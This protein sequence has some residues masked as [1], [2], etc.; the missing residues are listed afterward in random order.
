MF[1][2]LLENSGLKR[3]ASWASLVTQCL[4]LSFI[5]HIIAAVRS[6]GFY[7]AD[8]HFQIIE[9]M[10]YKLGRSP[11]LDL[12]LEYGQL[13][14]PW[15]MSAIFGVLTTLWKALKITSPFDWALSYRLLC[16]MAGFLCTAGLILNSY[17]WFPLKAERQPQWRTYS[18]LALTLI[19]YLPA[20][21]ARHSSE[22]LSGSVFF[23][24]ISL[25]GL[26]LPWGRSGLTHE[27]DALPDSLE[28]PKEV[29]TG[30]PAH[31]LSIPKIQLGREEWDLPL[32]K[33]R[34]KLPRTLAWTVGILFGLAFEFRYQTGFMI[35][36]A[37]LWLIIVTRISARSLLMILAGA[38]I[39]FILGTLADRWGYGQWT[40][41]PWNYL[42]YNLVQNHVSDSETSPWWDY[43]RRALT[44]SWP[45]LG[46]IL[47]LSFPIAWWKNPKHL[48]TWITL[49]L[50]LVHAIIGHKE[51]RFLFPL[52]HVG[53]V[54]LIL[55]IQG[56]MSGLLQRKGIQWLAWGIVGLNSVALIFTTVLPAWSPIR[57]YDQL[58]HFKP[59]GFHLYYKDDSLFD[60]GGAKMNFYKPS[61]LPLTHI[62]EYTDLIQE[63]KDNHRPLWVFTPRLSIPQFST[64][65]KPYCRVEFSTLPDWIERLNPMGV[66]SRVTNWTLHH[67]EIPERRH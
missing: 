41:A 31:L 55:S 22:N 62:N 9:F 3:D 23:I 11:A 10:N 59:Y 52:L 26:C 66:M 65:L 7:H 25:L 6:S 51:L 49:P 33:N 15:L 20:L 34:L 5:F 12:P 60:F 36:G 2:T 16:S 8:E 58:Y 43:F 44:E 46:L 32:T 53:P 1:N 56:R 38:V 28:T 18:V 37:L 4:A 27:Q 19:W 64:E 48:L 54:L 57:F 47:L 61:H 35:A 40:F 21:H 13:M 67:C 30:P 39:P 24:G 45:P 42:K 14:R 29:P 17:R 50:F 63:M